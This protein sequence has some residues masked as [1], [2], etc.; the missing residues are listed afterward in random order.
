MEIDNMSIKHIT[1][2]TV[3]QLNILCNEI[4]DLMDVQNQYKSSEISSPMRH[5]SIVFYGSN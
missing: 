1:F 5:G 3:L 2:K 4:S